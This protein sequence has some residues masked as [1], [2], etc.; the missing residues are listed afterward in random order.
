[1]NVPASGRSRRETTRHRARAVGPALVAAFL[2]AAGCGESEGREGGANADR[3]R[4]TA[5]VCLGSQLEALNP[6]TSPHLLAAD[7]LPVLYT[8]LVQ[9]GEGS[10]FE[11]GLAR[12]W[13]WS[14]DLLELELALRDDLVWHDGESV[15]AE[16]VVWTIRAA[17]DPEY[18]YWQGEDFARL[19]T[20]YTPSPGV[21][22]LSLSEPDAGMMEA[23]AQLPIL[24]R[25]RLADLSPEEFGRATYHREPVGSGPYEFVERRIDGSI[26]L[27]RNEQFPEDLGRGT[28][29]RIVLRPITEVSSQL[30]ELRTGNVSACVTGPEVAPEVEDAEALRNIVTGPYGV[31]IIAL[32]VDWP[33]LDDPRVRRALSAAL[34][35]SEIARL[36]SPLTEPSG[37]FMPRSS[38]FRSDTVLQPDAR[39]ELAA[40]LL[41]SAGWKL[42]GRSDIR[43]DS[44]GRPL[45]LTITGAQQ[46]G[47][48][49]TLV[50]G[51]LRR[52]GVDIDL[53]LL[54]GATYMG[55]LRDPEKRPAAMAMTLSPTKVQSYDPFSD[56][57]SEGFSNLAGYRNARVDS[58]VER[59]A[60]TIDPEQRRSIYHELQRRIAEDV[61]SLYTVY[62]PR[63][64]AVRNELQGVEVNPAGPFA[65]VTQWRIAK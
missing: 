26:L 12:E 32:R 20:V 9:Y 1:M 14:D 34:D 28:L 22:V 4:E 59:L 19:D 52:V 25:H 41:D 62:P 30:I 3:A 6:F 47:E 35:R 27:R 8:S 63:L 51:Q 13:S 31:Q 44:T 15:S 21:V 11:P 61:P 37:T 7:L 56:I 23:V 53:R 17:A 16:D 49:L 38:P 50:Q 46:F 39:P 64:L 5:V 40:A 2:F 43:T 10:R 48:M 65:T 58:L 45:R 18:A 29:A 42:R 54:E 57:H 55:M 60:S 33:P 36:N 24:P